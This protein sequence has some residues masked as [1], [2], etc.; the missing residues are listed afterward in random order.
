ML[1]VIN[2]IIIKD[3]NEQINLKTNIKMNLFTNFLATLI[4]FFV[5]ALWLIPAFMIYHGAEGM[6]AFAYVP[7]FVISI[8]WGVVVTKKYF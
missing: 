6:W 1:I 3:N 5:F 4:T 8:G 2:L 7:I